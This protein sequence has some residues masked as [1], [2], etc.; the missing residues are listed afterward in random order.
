MRRVHR[1]DGVRNVALQSLDRHL[2]MPARADGRCAGTCSMADQE[3]RRESADGPARSGSRL[4]VHH[5]RSNSAMD[6]TCAVCGKHV[7][8]ARG[9]EREALVVHQHV[10]VARERGRVAGNVDDAPRP[11][12][13]QRMDQRRGALARRIDQV[14]VEAAV[15]REVGLEQ[16]RDLELRHQAVGGGVLRARARP[17]AR[18]PRSR[19]PA[20]RARRSAARNCR[21]RRTG[22][23]RARPAADRAGA[24]RA[25]PARG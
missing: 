20:R 4:I 22:R 12:L 13:G 2:P 18:C 6:S 14:F 9:G 15:V 5:G 10:G 21:C 25:R 11:I 19:S 17:A 23:R 1:D 3:D 7:D 24:S 8:H 16:V